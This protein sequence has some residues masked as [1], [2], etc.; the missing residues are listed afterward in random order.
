[1]FEHGV[2]Q[3]LLFRGLSVSRG[4][5]KSQK[6]TPVSREENGHGSMGVI[7]TKVKTKF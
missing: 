5:L 7:R 2:S 4:G 1:M 6:D 3:L